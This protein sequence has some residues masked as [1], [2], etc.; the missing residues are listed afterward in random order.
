MRPYRAGR[1]HRHI[2]P[3]M[4]RIV[5]RALGQTPI[6][7][8]CCTFICMSF[9]RRE[10]GSLGNGQAGSTRARIRSF[11]ISPKTSAHNITTLGQS[12]LIPAGQMFFSVL[13]V[14]RKLGS[15]RNCYTRS[16]CAHTSTPS[17][18]AD[19]RCT[20]PDAILLFGSSFLL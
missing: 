5:V 17:R 4:L 8:L 3:E 18:W 7:V 2:I 12:R 11:V 13:G 1:S 6:V 15:M 16:R 10:L 9:T 14:S 20:R 19:R